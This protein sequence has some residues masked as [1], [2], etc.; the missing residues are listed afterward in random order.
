[1]W[2]VPRDPVEDIPAS[3]R[4]RGDDRL[5]HHVQDDLVGHEFAAIQVRL[6]GLAE[7]G[8]PRDVIAQQLAGRD[9]RDVE[10]RGDQRTLSPLARARRGDHQYPHYPS[11]D[12]IIRRPAPG[13]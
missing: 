3:G 6:D 8:P 4:L 13:R 12:A 5:S 10:V 7:R 9:V 2:H 1:M 11:P